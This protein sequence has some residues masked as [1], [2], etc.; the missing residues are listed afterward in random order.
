MRMKKINLRNFVFAIY[1]TNKKIRDN[2]R[3]NKA[4]QLFLV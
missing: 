3:D 1:K 2:K 4:S